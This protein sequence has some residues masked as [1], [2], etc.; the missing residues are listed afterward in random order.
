[1]SKAKQDKKIKGPKFSDCVW[2][3]TVPPQFSNKFTD[4][5]DLYLKIKQDSPNTVIIFSTG[6]LDPKNLKPQDHKKHGAIYVSISNMPEFFDKKKFNTNAKLKK[7][8]QNTL[9]FAEKYIGPHMQN[10]TFMSVEIM[11][12]QMREFNKIH[13]SL[14]K[15]SA[16]PHG[17]I[18]CR[19][20]NSDQVTELEELCNKVTELEELCENS[21]F[22]GY[23][24]LN[25][26]DGERYKIKRE[27]FPSTDSNQENKQRGGHKQEPKNYTT[28]GLTLCKE[29]GYGYDNAVLSMLM[30]NTT[31]ENEIVISK[32][33]DIEL[34]VL[35]IDKV[36]ET[37]SKFPFQGDKML[38]IFETVGSKDS[39]RYTSNPIIPNLFTNPLEYQLKFDG[40]TGLVHKDRDGKIH[41]LIKFQIDIFEI[42]DSSGQKIYRFGFM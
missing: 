9:E 24:A 21:I 20:V 35:P 26:T 40:E 1:M 3:K 2:A 11:G 4:A 15:A 31:N 10:N 36:I 7:H 38:N 17:S 37:Q 13:P 29:S 28:E 23:V 16:I 18:I 33:N 19:K 42:I 32:M 6:E 8:F 30:D 14:P 41:L 25:K 34:V 5:H 27:Y 12:I 39:Y 22:E